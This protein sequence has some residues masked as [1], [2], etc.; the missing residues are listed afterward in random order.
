M[1]QFDYIR[2]H[3]KIYFKECPSFVEI[4]SLKHEYFI[5]M[6]VLHP[7]CYFIVPELKANGKVN[8]SI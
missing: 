1:I 7:G 8:V 2:N 6:T 3:F 4:E 5:V